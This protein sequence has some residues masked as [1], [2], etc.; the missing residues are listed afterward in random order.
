M[1]KGGE[2][3][4]ELVEIHYAADSIPVKY[5]RLRSLL[6][7]VCKDLTREDGL[8]FSSLFSRLNFVCKKTGLSPAKTWQIHTFRVHANEVI[9]ARLDPAKETYLQDLKAFSGC[10]HHFY[11][12]EIP[13]ELAQHL[14][15]TDNYPG[16]NILKG[17]ERSRAR[18]EVTAVDEDFIYGMDES[19]PT[20]DPV[21]IKH[22]VKDLNEEFNPSIGLLKEGSQINL[23]DFIIDGDGIYFPALIILEPDYLVDTSSLAE[24]IKEYGSHPLNYLRSKFEPLRNTKHILLGNVA[25][26]FLDEFVNEGKEYPV[27][28]ERTIKD[29]FR[30]APFDFSTCTDL[31]D[32]DNELAFFRDT[33]LHFRHIQRVVNENFPANG[34]DRE[35][36]IVEPNFICEHLGILGRLDFLEL[37]SATGGQF[38]VELKSGRAPYPE[39]N[40]HL[41]GKNHRAQAF[42]YQIM[43][44]KV[45]GID[46]RSLKTF[47]L[48]SRYAEKDA[49]L[50][51]ADPFLSAIKTILD[52]RNHIV[53]N[54]R[55]IAFDKTGEAT[56]SLID[57]LSPDNLILEQRNSSFVNN[58][59]VP[60]I[61]E[62]RSFF[63]V[64][65]P[66]E[67]KYFH[68]F[69][70]FV[71]KEHYISK[72]GGAE[73]DGSRG[74]SSLWHSSLEEKTDTG[75]I[76]IDLMILENKAEKEDHT[77]RLHIPVG[78]SGSLHNFRQGDLIIFYERNKEEDNVTNRQTFKGAI[79]TLHRHEMTIRLRYRQRNPSVLP[80]AGRYA[81]EHDH[82]DSSY[83]AM[84]R[85]LYAFLRANQDRK[86][87][88][89]N[90]R[91]PLQDGNSFLSSLS[92]ASIPEDIRPIILQAKAAKDYFLLIG[93]PG[94]GKTSIAIRHMVEEFY[95]DPSMNI[96]L[97]SYTNRAVDEICDSLDRV[98][99]QPPYVRVGSEFSCAE[100]H[101][102]KLLECLI[103]D[104]GTRQEVRNRIQEHRIFAGTVASISG[105]LELFKLKHFQV[106]IIDEASQILEPHLLGILSAKNPGGANA[107]GKFILVGDHRQL[108]S[109][110]LQ[111]DEDSKVT[112]PSLN[113]MGLFDRR[114][115]L[116]E[117]LYTIHKGDK[118]SLVRGMLRRQGRMHPEIARF[119]NE[120]FYQ[121]LLEAVPLPHQLGDIAFE[122]FD[123]DQA[124]QKII[125]TQRLV[126]FQSEKN[127]GGGGNKT[128]AH[129]ADLTAMLIDNIY[130]LYQKNGI[131]F[132]AAKS[133]GVITPYRNQ[134]ALI[135]HKIHDIGIPVLNEI[136]IDTVER[137]QGS[138]RDI[139][140]YSF[141]VNRAWQLDL[142]ANTMEE[143][144]QRIDR[145]LNVALTRAREQLFITGNPSILAGNP[146]YNR[147]IGFIRR[148][149]AYIKDQASPS[150]G[151]QDQ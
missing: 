146:I 130:K 111:K 90:A 106:A 139:I 16:R 26:L 145:K 124:L 51:P 6:E 33:R 42:L 103:A 88:L 126:F 19:S 49:N 78:R 89:L 113:A 85:G 69:Y 150:T 71:T 141:S 115:S 56:K 149:G 132:D 10:L 20:E 34:I 79:Q 62:F 96:L 45:L 39:T 44:Q 91:P 27:L 116:F 36:G 97:L 29:A 35:N 65:R 127:K 128:N 52:L 38:V 138:E 95:S 131:P 121:G 5:P 110:V 120:E 135:R 25:N 12:T 15:A 104:C 48:Y 22:H 129:E 117:R 100:K 64:A 125:A 14:P 134:V 144:G 108:P 60:Q 68:S 83:N 66:L 94:S 148:H 43:V 59:I 147:L 53:A 99:G 67:L 55:K 122:H 105:K 61:E 133:I 140:I 2:F 3:F 136:Q 76:L 143:E 114:S 46:F 151:S 8:P 142:L 84:Y 57:S 17:E 9:H 107:I 80:I 98:A 37:R 54:E 50:R 73:Y 87:L 31:I 28:Y 102:G 93:P 18:V 7:R 112:D 86:D 92:S 11:G 4:E 137:F 81:I 23:I 47:V 82:L 72:T 75:E 101:R 58:Y 30:S 63:Q 74:F 40:T 21:K 70:T 13:S 77:I 1:Y 32:R 123:G 119:P 41:I 118:G 24:C 109:V